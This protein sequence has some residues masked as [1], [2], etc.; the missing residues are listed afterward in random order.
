MQCPVYCSTY[1]QCFH[2]QWMDM[3]TCPDCHWY[4]FR[5]LKHVS[6]VHGRI[7]YSQ[8]C[9]WTK[10]SVCPDCHWYGPKCPGQAAA[11]LSRVKTTHI[12]STTLPNRSHSPLP[13]LYFSLFHPWSI[14][15][16]VLKINHIHEF[17]CKYVY[18]KS[19]KKQFRMDRIGKCRAEAMS[20]EQNTR[21]T[22]SAACS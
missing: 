12:R 3:P 17:E 15:P 7:N 11:T 9:A 8:Q 2:M 18:I 14:N 13:E 4:G 22:L 5:F 19:F 16:K 21:S 10:A 6:C 20:L 1:W